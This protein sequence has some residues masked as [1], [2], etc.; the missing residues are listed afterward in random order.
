MR[1]LAPLICSSLLVTPAAGRTQ[2]GAARDSA[3]LYLEAGLS[4]AAA[5]DT[6]AALVELRKAVRAS[7]DYA[8]ARYYLGILLIRSAATA[9]ERRAAEGHLLRAL[10]LDPNNPLYASELARW[11]DERQLTAEG[12]RL[13]ERLRAPLRASLELDSMEL[14]DQAKEWQ[15]EFEE[16]RRREYS[17]RRLAYRCQA[18]VGRS[19]LSYRAAA[20]EGPWESAV[21]DSARDA[22]IA[23]LTSAADSDRVALIIPRTG[24]VRKR[25]AGIPADEWIMGQRV[26]YLV[27]DGRWR[28]A[29]A[30]S[31]RCPIT[32]RW[33]C[34]GLA[35]YALQLAGEYEAADSAFGVALAGMPA[36]ARD[37]WTDISLFLDGEAKRL[38]EESADPQRDS[39]ERRFWW[40]ADPL[41][42]KPVNDRRSEHWARIVVSDLQVQAESG[43]GLSWGE[44]LEEIVLRYGWPMGWVYGR[45]TPWS[46][47]IVSV[48]SKQARQFL[49]RAHFVLD[50]AAIKPDEWRPT[51]P[52]PFAAHAPAYVE[53]VNTL[54]H[55][56][57]AFRRGD[58]VVVVVAYDQSADSGWLGHSVEAGLFLA[59][60]ELADPVRVRQSGSEPRDVFSVTV[61][62]EPTLLSVELLS[63]SA[64][65]AARARYGLRLRKIPRTLLALS[66]ILV[67]VTA[68]PLPG[69]LG[70]AVPLARG[71]LRV[72]AGERLGLYW[73]VYGLGPEAETLALSVSLHQVAEGR[74]A[75]L[76]QV[77]R[78]DAAAPLTLRWREVVPAYTGVWGRSLALDLPRD[79]RPGLYV[80]Y[81]VAEARG[82]E[83]V[84]TTRALLV[85]E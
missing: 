12:R 65:R 45:G 17:R 35:G 19:C 56:T 43:Y 47:D 8:D 69:S 33:W 2:G 71:S 52:A 84:R 39:L 59:P 82:R 15:N 64:R 46:V 5:G 38:Y 26:R 40:L 78:N 83:P 75:D 21:V 13:L 10:A 42:L 54:E 1:W 61:A 16:L 58:S 31:L 23:V 4:R 37:R 44:D 57:A 20:G 73:E 6:A 63:E 51:S 79:S 24:G 74:L 76:E 36:A 81:L 67:T 25:V 62:A 55:Q 3:P 29:V 22:L 77:A 32:R 60:N 7:P 18:R 85:E 53:S 70:G 14:L 34:S 72:R 9:S 30:L 27:E 11:V 48:Y 28:E 66:D 80:L 68:D 49:P 41:Y 50:P